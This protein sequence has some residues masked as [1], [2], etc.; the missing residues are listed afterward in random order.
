MLI[1]G[2]EHSKVL[3][4]QKALISVSVPRTFGGPRL[5]DHCVLD[6]PSRVGDDTSSINARNDAVHRLTG[7]PR[8]TGAGFAMKYQMRFGYEHS[9]A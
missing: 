6:H 1:E 8:R 4:A 7:H 2:I 3:V 9:I 5:G